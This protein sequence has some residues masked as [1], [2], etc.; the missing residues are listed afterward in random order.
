MSSFKS[1]LAPSVVMLT[2]FVEVFDATVINIVLPQI[3]STFRVT[4]AHAAWALT[5][6]ITANSLVLP[7]AS[8]LT[9]SLGR[10]WLLSCALAIFAAASILGGSAHSLAI[11]VF[12]RTVQGA[13]GALLQPLGTAIALEAFQ[14]TRA[15]R[16]LTITGTLTTLAPIVGPFSGGLITDSLG[17]R[18]AFYLTVPATVTILAVVLIFLRKDRIEHSK[19]Y[20]NAGNVAHIGLLAISVGALQIIVTRGADLGWW[21]SHTIQ[22]LGAVVVVSTW[23]LVRARTNDHSANGSLLASSLYRAS[24]LTF[25]IQSF[26]LFSSVVLLPFELQEVF[27]MS[28]A[29]AGIATAPRG[30]GALLGIVVGG[31]HFHDLTLRHIVL[32]SFLGNGLST[33]VLGYQSARLNFIYLYGGQLLSGFSLAF[34]FVPLAAAMYGATEEDVVGASGFFGLFTGL[35]ASAGIAA[36][37]MLLTYCVPAGIQIHTDL[38]PNPSIKKELISLARGVELICPPEKVPMMYAANKIFM[39]IAMLSFL[40]I[41]LAACL[42]DLKRCRL[43]SSRMPL[44]G[45]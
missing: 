3:A 10:K 35:A 17:W 6:Y 21:K 41:P 14:H 25:T 16:A 34:L 30:I 19:H 44:A 42:K 7:L 2:G 29:A 32:L 45:G 39:G 5:A 23:I 18:W 11:L 33:M 12:C 40:Y 4:P 26:I 8:L 13:A 37:L 28:A 31:R 9:V 38:S 24:I 43:H 22:T 36:S 20:V 27:G 15:R 1:L